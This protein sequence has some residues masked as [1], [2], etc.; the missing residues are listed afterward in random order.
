MYRTAPDTERPLTTSMIE[1]LMECHERE[2]MNLFPCKATA[3]GAKGLVDRGLLRAEFI[4]DGDGK[5]YMCVLLTL[6]GR[7]YLSNHL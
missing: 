1:R 6:K 4:K 3:Q 2:M 5:R 7:H